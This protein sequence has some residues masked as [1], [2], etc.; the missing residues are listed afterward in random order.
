M[1]R[2]REK[3]RKDPIK[4]EE[5]KRKDRERKMRNRRLIQDLNE[6]EQR[7]IRKNWQERSKRCRE[8]KKIEEKQAEY[9]TDFLESTTPPQSPQ[10]IERH[11]EGP[12]VLIRSTPRDRGKR[13]ARKNRDKMRK[14]IKNL[15]KLVYSLQKTVNKYRKRASRA[16]KNV[17]S[18]IPSPRFKVNHMSKNQTV[19]PEVK[20]KLL[21]AEVIGEQVRRNFSDEKRNRNN[22][23]FFSMLNGEIITKYKFVTHIGALTSLK[24]NKCKQLPEQRIL[25]TQKKV[26]TFLEKDENSRLTAGKKETITRLKNKKQKR[27]LNYCLKNLHKKFIASHPEHKKMSYATFSKLRLFWILKPSDKDRDTCLC[28]QYS[29]ISLMVQSLR[30]NKIINECNINEVIKTLCCGDIPEEKCLE[31]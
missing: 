8:R 22:R 1:R 4:Y 19:P 28:K 3:I 10:I 11:L 12:S 24:L 18:S 2:A 17:A 14:R 6:R 16:N 7:S 20:R 15:E 26:I 29:N 5:E 25:Q 21:F 30:N 27:F 23:Y 9:E 31:R 13:I